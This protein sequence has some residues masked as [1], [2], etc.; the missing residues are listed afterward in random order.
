MIKNF[1]IPIPKKGLKIF[2][3]GGGQIIFGYKHFFYNYK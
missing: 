2:F 3:D 1:K